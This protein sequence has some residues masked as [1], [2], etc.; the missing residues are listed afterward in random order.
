MVLS[1]L[2]AVLRINDRKYR[3]IINN[4]PATQQLLD[5]FLR[6][7]HYFWLCKKPIFGDM[8]APLRHP[9]PRGGRGRM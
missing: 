5:I 2:P 3:E 7:E 8:I 1:E 4:Q 6:T 9:C